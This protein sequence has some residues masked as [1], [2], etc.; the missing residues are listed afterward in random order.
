MSALAIKPGPFAP[1]R[2]RHL[3]TQPAPSFPAPCP[4]GMWQGPPLASLPSLTP[5]SSHPNLPAHQPLVASRPLHRLLPRPVPPS[6]VTWHSTAPLPRTPLPSKPLLK[7]HLDLAPASP[8]VLEVLVSLYSPHF[9]SRSPSPSTGQLEGRT[10]LGSSP[11]RPGVGLMTT[12]AG[13]PGLGLG[14]ESALG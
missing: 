7:P 13:R 14:P 10:L 12:N 1:P 4:K 6:R 11:A 3:G 8:L 5:S 9:P 2:D